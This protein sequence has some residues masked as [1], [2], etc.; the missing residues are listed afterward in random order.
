MA[1]KDVSGGGRGP[2]LESTHHL[3]VEIEWIYISDFSGFCASVVLH[4]YPH[5]TLFESCAGC[6]DRSFHVSFITV[7]ECPDI[8]IFF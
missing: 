4:F 2:F 7:I 6:L 3:P 1:V 8:T 5:G